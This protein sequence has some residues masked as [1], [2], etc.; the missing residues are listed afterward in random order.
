M[1]TA[2]RVFIVWCVI[3]LLPT[4]ALISALY[5]LAILPL[6][7]RERTRMFLDLIRVGL[8]EG[9]SVEQ[10]IVSVA[11]S[12]D[13]E[14]GAR[15]YLL[16]AYLEQGRRF[17]EAVQVASTGMPPQ[18]IAVLKAA[19]EAGGLAK[20]LPA[21]RRI[22]TDASSRAHSSMNYLVLALMLFTPGLLA[23]LPMWRIYVWPKMEVLWID[24]ETP[25]PQLTQFLAN[26]VALV[27]SCYGLMIGFYAMI[28]F[29]YLAHPQFGKGGGVLRL[30]RDWFAWQIPWARKRGLRNFSVMLGTLLDSEVPEPTALRLASESTD[31]SGFI[32]RCRKMA[33]KLKQGSNLIE[34]VG[35][36]DSSGEL[37]WRL[38]NAAQG[39]HDFVR[40][41]QGWHESLEGK[42]FQAEQTAAHLITS[43]FIIINGAF[44][45]LFVSA[46]FLTIVSIINEGT[47]W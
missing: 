41:L 21:A 5:S 42:A 1:G 27:L 43:S 14:L 4:L 22:L 29:F 33:D 25:M 44:I 17:D 15:F 8:S 32:R 23:A 26:N 35:E 7:R 9:R 46:V 28:T 12:R 2:F 47:L 36:L 6:R 38:S 34:V 13:R 37:G 24:L 39:K 40:S 20:L 30:F 45:G 11:E 16:A 19:P 18:I 3:W 10:T 31:N